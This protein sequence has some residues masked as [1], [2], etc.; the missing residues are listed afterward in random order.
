M[1]LS[2]I[3]QKGKTIV[4]LV[5]CFSQGSEL[6]RLPHM[7]MVHPTFRTTYGP[8]QVYGRI[9]YLNR[10]SIVEEGRSSVV[11]GAAPFDAVLEGYSYQVAADEARR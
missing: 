8:R 4:V 3:F 11:P 10:L 2:C 9:L 7:D 1:A 6:R 5:V